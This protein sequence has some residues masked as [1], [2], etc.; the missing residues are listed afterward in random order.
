[1]ATTQYIGARYVPLFAD[2]AEWDSTKQYEPLT[3][4]IHKGNSYTS[5]QY[6]PAGIEITNE[7]FWALTGNYNAQVEAYRKEVR[8]ILPLDE[9]PTE[10]S[11]KAVTSDGIEKAITKAVAAETTRATDAE[12]TNAT[13]IAN[14]VTR[15]KSAEETLQN[16][17]NTNATAISTETTRAKSAEETNAR[18]IANEIVRATDKETEIDS[19]FSKKTEYV[20]PEQFGAIGDGANDDT[21][22]LQDAIDSGKYVIGVGDY[23]CTDTITVSNSHQRIVLKSIISDAADYALSVMHGTF[24]QEIVINQITAAHNGVLATTDKITARHNMHFGVISANNGIAF[25]FIGGN[26]GVLDCHIS[27][28]VWEGTTSGLTVAPSA[29]FIG[30]ITF[31][32][33][34]F[35]A[36]NESATQLTLDSTNGSITQ[37][38]FPNCSVEPEVNTTANNGILVNVVNKIEF[39]DG[40][41]RTTELT[42]KTGYILKIAGNVTNQ[43][44]N[45]M[46]F[47]FDH[48][49]PSKIDL[50]ELTMSR[51]Y[52]LDT[53]ICTI[54]CNKIVFA[55]QSQSLRLT[56]KGNKKHCKPIRGRYV[57][58]K[59]DYTWDFSKQ[60]QNAIEFYKDG[61]L[62]IPEW[63]DPDEDSLMLKCAGH[64]V[65]IV[66]DEYGTTETIATL[67]DSE[68]IKLSFYRD[69]NNKLFVV[70]S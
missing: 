38:H 36:S 34:R 63:F 57:L 30:N 6:V 39:C 33:I 16:G 43:L 64:S 14:E 15:A 1:M 52:A 26:G 45:G 53:P 54:D 12:E 66:I 9:T 58:S 10:G 55:S 70:K 27:G 59:G 19:K 32:S 29:S 13:A 20:T 4:V 31:D 24:G 11:T 68:W 67:S 41:F 23:H 35:T 46:H 37:L 21:K 25:N 7:K 56:I 48:V 62:N 69:N 49:L 2:P 17:I 65:A 28:Q 51:Y 22:A 40:Y 60:I 50:S 61:T 42:G 47:T 18:A 8:T 3:I 5:R 44:S